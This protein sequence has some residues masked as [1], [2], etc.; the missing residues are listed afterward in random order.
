[1]KYYIET[2]GCQ[3]NVSDSELVSSI[4]RTA[5]HTEVNSIDEA[6]LLLFNTCSVREHAEQRVLGR[7]ANERHR[8]K[9]K[10]ELKIILLGCMA[11][12][13]GQ[14][15]L[16]ENCGIDYVVGVDQYRA[17]PA[18][19]NQEPSALI[20]FDFDEVYEELMPI[21]SGSRCGFVTIMRG[22]NN[23][24][25]YC[26]VPYVRGRE[27]SRPYPEILKD[28]QLAIDNDLKDI[29][30]LGQNVNSYQWQDLS[31]PKLLLKLN[32]IKGLHRLRFVTSH[33]KDFSDDLILIMR[34]CDKVC[35]HIHLPMQSGDSGIL[36]MMNRGYSYEHYL[37]RIL[38]LRDAIPEVS[39]TTD[40]IAGFPGETEAQFES[41]LSAMREI[42]FDYAFCFKYSPRSGTAAADSKDQIP[43]EIRLERLQ[44]MIDLQR[45]ITLKKFRAQIGKTVEIY[46]EDFSKKSMAQLSGKTRDFKIAVVSGNESQIGKMVMAKVVDATAGTLICE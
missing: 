17:L 31:F 20:D 33:P 34:D 23:F 7:I 38:K 39:I 28:L 3:M 5:G 45:E 30:L 35:E 37:S 19:I 43:E 42:E 29:T 16:N 40:L 24:C 44:R 8:K 4:L 11:Q 21:H 25:S 41:T 1:M 2:Y 26:I 9:H 18:I 6:D 36:D 15:L 46:I 10:P 22:C 12:R 32:D 27:R 13:I 14:S